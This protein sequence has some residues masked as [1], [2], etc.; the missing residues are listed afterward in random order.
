MLLVSISF[1]DSINCGLKIFEKISRKFQKGKLEF[2]AHWQ[3]FINT[4]H[5]HCIYSYLHTIFIVLILSIIS[6]LEMN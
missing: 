2:A 3:L 1:T 6:N 4:Y 5:L